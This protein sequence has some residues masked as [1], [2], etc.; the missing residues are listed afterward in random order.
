MLPSVPVTVTWVAAVAA[1]VS[2]EDAPLVIDAGAAV[3][4]TVGCVAD[5]V[6]VAVAVV[7]P[8]A[9]VAVAV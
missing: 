4:V 5:I 7:E 9:F 6:T 3:M 8:F 1:I 2:V